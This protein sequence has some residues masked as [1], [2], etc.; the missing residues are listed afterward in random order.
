MTTYGVGT[1]NCRHLVTKPIDVTWCTGHKKLA[2]LFVLSLIDFFQYEQR[3]N[4]QTP[5]II[6]VHLF[7][8]HIHT[9][10]SV[11]CT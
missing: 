1:I 10:L 4:S 9:V 3:I 5:R 6:S 2:L 7:I 11:P 8:I